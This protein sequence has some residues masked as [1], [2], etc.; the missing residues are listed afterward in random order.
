[1]INRKELEDVLSTYK[2]SKSKHSNSNIDNKS[3]PDMLKIFRGLIKDGIPP[4]QEEFIN[5]FKKQKPDLKLR[6]IVSRLK[7]AYLSFIREYHLG[8]LLIEHFHKV[9][10]DEQIDI[11]GVDY[12][13]YYKKHRFNL[14]AFVNTKGGR[15][16]RAVK[17]NRHKFY[18]KHVDLPMTLS[19]GTRVGDFIFYNDTHM[20]RL[21]RDMDSLVF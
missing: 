5:E 2:I 4:T 3:L 11:A 14:H 12:V 19:S 20:K 13:I 10:Y 9:K 6:G 1:M 17:N 7:K 15:Y 16:W 21:K 18:G 8:F